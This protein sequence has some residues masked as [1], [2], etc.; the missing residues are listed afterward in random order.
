MRVA[1]AEDAGWNNAM[2]SRKRAGEEILNFV[3]VPVLPKER[4]R[5]VQRNAE[6]L[7]RGLYRGER[8]GVC[9]RRFGVGYHRFGMRDLSG[10]SGLDASGRAS[11]RASGSVGGMG[12][13]ADHGG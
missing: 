9:C 11:G 1:G 13:R 6:F 3:V 2:G 8:K 5:M 7:Y 10:L 4:A 12:D